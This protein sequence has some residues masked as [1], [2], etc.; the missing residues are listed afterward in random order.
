MVS[1]VPP[2]PFLYDLIMYMPFLVVVTCTL[3]ILLLRCGKDGSERNLIG[4][5]ESDC[6]S[7]SVIWPFLTPGTD[8]VKF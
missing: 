6:V 3:I 5:P 1:L 7:R 4:R 8:C 2:D